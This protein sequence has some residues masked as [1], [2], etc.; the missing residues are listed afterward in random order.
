M[1]NV[2]YSYQFMNLYNSA[3][4]PSSVHCKNTA[5]VN[6][7]SRYLL[8]KALSVYEFTGLPEEWAV[9]YFKYCIF[10]FGYLAVFNTE[11]YG[12]ICQEC[13]LS[14]TYTLFRQPNIAIITN[15][16][17]K[18][19]LQLK[20]GKECEIIKLQ[21]DY[22]NVMDIVSVY[23]DMM[24]LCLETA[25]INL[26]NS[27]TSYI[28]MSDNKAAS[29]SFKKLYDKVASGEPM[30]VIDKNLL[31]E[32]GSKNWDFFLQ[33][34]GQNFI[35][36]KVMD[37]LKNLEDQFNTRIG[38]PN[39]NTQKRERLITDEVKANDVDTHSLVYLWLNTLRDGL[40]RVNKRFSL[41]LGVEYKYEETALEVAEN[42]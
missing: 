21:P 28:F 13:T 30:A 2:P 20:I 42:G 17:F 3:I 37:A 15:P 23:A 38:I 33:N 9:N 18:K 16:V 39:A 11:R 31:N 14:D 24:A 27:K 25:G 35:V 7:F 12:V 1:N 6:Y 19:S 41:N 4:S 36:D 32:D 40:E 22:G 5:L 8:Q 34:V 29:E 26:L 10:A